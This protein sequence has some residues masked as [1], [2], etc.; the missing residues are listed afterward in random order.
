[1]KRFFT[2]RRVIP[3]A[4]VATLGVGY[5]V[6]KQDDFFE[7]SKNLEIFGKLYKEVNTRYVDDVSPTDLMRTGIDAMLN[8]LD[9]YTVYIS[10]SEIEDF[11]FM[12]TGQYGGVGAALTKIN[13]RYLI[14]ELYKDDPADKAG[15]KLGDEVLEVE[16]EVLATTKK[17][18]EEIKELMRGEKGSII[19]LK[20]KRD[21]EAQPIT[22]AIAR[23]RIKVK[24]VPYYGM[25]NDEIGYISLTGFMQD[26]GKEVED[27]VLALKKAHPAMSGVVLDVRGN[28]GGRLDEAVNIVNVFVPQNEKVVETRGRQESS[29]RIHTGHNRPVD[30]QIPVVV[31]VNSKS[32]SASE[33]VAGALQDLDRAVIVG[34]RSFGKGLVQN[35]R[36]LSY[37]TQLKITTAKYYTPSGRCIQAIDYSKHNPDGSVV[38]VADSLKQAFKTRAG[39][40]VFDGGGIQPDVDVKNPDLHTITKELDQ[41]GIIFDFATRYVRHHATAPDVRKFKVDD[42]IYNEF[43]AFVRERKFNYQTRAEH[44]LDRLKESLK[45]DE[46]ADKV[47]AEV[48]ALA[49]KLIAQKENDLRSFR[50]EISRILRLEIIRRYHYEQGGIEAAFQDDPYMLEAI[51][52]LNDTGRYNTVL[53]RK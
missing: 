36:P 26:A 38:K 24:N 40:T 27:A 20:I 17:K 42:A 34:Q 1:M 47:S 4:L 48:S 19:H 15:L 11:K 31:L 51:K 12:N 23:D 52:V 44:Q 7:I 8:S 9:P 35:V 41:A 22:V 6:E 16:S 5:V 53:A 2:L 3:L 39:R 30:T 45:E 50:E 49:S 43:V 37:N 25:V 18:E 14:T 29:R 13:G 10:E 46:Y 33:I 21:G 32:A 28:P